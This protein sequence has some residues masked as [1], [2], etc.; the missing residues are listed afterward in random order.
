M[1]KELDD[2]SFKIGNSNSTFNDLIENPIS[3]SLLSSSCLEAIPSCHNCVY[4]PYC[5][6]CPVYNYVSQKNI[7]GK[8]PE[9]YRCKINFGILNYIFSILKANSEESSIITSWLE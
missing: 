5:G 4:Q 3:K 7:F 1:L 6:T 9:N 8:Q 2:E